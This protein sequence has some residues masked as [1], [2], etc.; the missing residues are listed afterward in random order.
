MT[1]RTRVKVCCISSVAEAR[2]AVANG[3]D[4]LG[5]VSAMPSGPG[6]IPEPLI[7]E[8]AATVP[9]PV[10]TFLLTSEPR[11][12]AIVDQQR[13]CRTNTLQL[14]DRLEHGTYRDLRAALPGV[15]LVQVI[16][17]TG[18]D[19]VAEAC[20]AAGA[21]AD[22]ILLDSG[23]QRLAVK[24]LGGTG[25]THDWAVSRRV[26]EAVPVPVFLAGG[27]NPANVG[28]AIRAVR[29]FGVDVCS[30]LRTGGRLD[31][32]KLAAFVAA[33]AAADAAVRTE[34]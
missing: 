2:L 6:P 15:A 11:A 7:A 29:P 12:D 25:R 20:R 3:A 21:G 18:G 5:L 28:E 24:L 10:A 19:A 34:H 1:G 31:A 32:E 22:A 16:H 23:D 26:V 8:V 13:R 30:G 27:L 9:P 14:V 33:V 4:A 17:V